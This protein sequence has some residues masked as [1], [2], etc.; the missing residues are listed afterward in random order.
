MPESTELQQFI[1]KVAKLVTVNEGHNLTDTFKCS[2][3]DKDHPIAEHYEGI[4]ES[5]INAIHGLGYSIVRMQ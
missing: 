5:V 3:C 2:N 4:T 1:T